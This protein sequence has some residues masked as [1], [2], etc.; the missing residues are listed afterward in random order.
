M[1]NTVISILG[2]KGSGK[3]TLARELMRGRSRVLVFDTLGE[4]DTQ[5]IFYSFDEALRAMERSIPKARFQWGVRL[6]DM[7]DYVDLFELAFELPGTLLVFEE[8]SLFCSPSY[9]PPSLS[10]LVRYAR[11][12]EID[13]VFVSRRASEV[14]RDLTAQSDFIV[15]FRQHEPRDL[16]YLSSV[17]GRDV[18]AVRTLPAFKVAVIQGDPAD[19]PPAIQ[20]QLAPSATPLTGNHAPE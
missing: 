17:S 8:T 14:N 4:Y 5:R 1:H 15:T 10:K 12:R 20:A 13:L 19:A 9:L 16:Q 3:T 2:H 18:S 11:H 7:A 6:A